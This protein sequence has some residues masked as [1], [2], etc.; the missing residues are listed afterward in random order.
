MPLRSLS[1]LFVALF[2]SLGLAQTASA[3]PTKPS[4]S[5]EV[6]LNGST[7]SISVTATPNATAILIYPN[8]PGGGYFMTNDGS[9]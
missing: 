6:C 4:Y 7:A 2:V 1:T 9:G 8:P 3:Q 5:G